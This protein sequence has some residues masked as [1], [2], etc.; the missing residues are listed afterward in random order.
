MFI[1]K[2]N[3][4]WYKLTSTFVWMVLVM[5]R[6]P[7]FSFGF[8]PCGYGWPLWKGRQVCQAPKK[9]RMEQCSSILFRG[10][11][12]LSFGGE[13]GNRRWKIE[14]GLIPSWELTYPIE[15]HLW[16][17]ISFSPGRICIHSLGRV[18]PIDGRNHKWVSGVVSPSLSGLP[19]PLQMSVS[20]LP[21]PFAHWEVGFRLACL[22]GNG[23]GTLT[24][25]SKGP[26]RRGKNDYL[27]NSRL[28]PAK[29]W[30]VF[31]PWIPMKIECLR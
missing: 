28:F 21:G 27:G 2:K 16:R 10:G 13:M 20:K 24:G 15:G 12:L 29:K 18:S 19:H 8:F 3:W 1:P 5:M 14:A 6:V 25:E 11:G 31:S 22:G 23:F 9:K 4:K 17:W 26:T 7:F 30:H